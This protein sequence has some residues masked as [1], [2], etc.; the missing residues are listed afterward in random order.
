MVCDFPMPAEPVSTANRN[1]LIAD[2]KLRNT[3]SVSGVNTSRS[4]LPKYSKSYGNDWPIWYARHWPNLYPVA[5]IVASFRHPQCPKQRNRT[6]H[7]YENYHQE[8]D[9]QSKN[10]VHMHATTYKNHYI[11]VMTIKKFSPKGSCK[12]IDFATADLVLELLGPFS[13]LFELLFVLPTSIKLRAWKLSN[14]LNNGCNG[15]S[16]GVYCVEEGD[17]IPPPQGCGQ[18]LKQRKTFFSLVSLVMTVVHLTISWTSSIAMS[19]H[20][21]DVH[22][23]YF[24]F[25][26]YPQ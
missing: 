2:V 11:P 3:R 25:F 10:I 5:T 8:I 6:T 13:P 24:L 7:T 1:D 9:L 4:T 17:R 22:Y 12:L 14:T 16:F 26:L 23:Y 20:V 21:P 15:F 19:S 18:A